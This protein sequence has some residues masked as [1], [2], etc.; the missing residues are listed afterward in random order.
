MMVSLLRRCASTMT[1]RMPASCAATRAGARLARSVSSVIE[2]N[3]RAPAVD[4]RPSQG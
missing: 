1:D 3:V 4:A 2:N